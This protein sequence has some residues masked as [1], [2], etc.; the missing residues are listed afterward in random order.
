MRKAEI[1]PGLEEMCSGRG[2]YWDD[3][4]NETPR[5][6]RNLRAAVKSTEIVPTSQI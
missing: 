2:T 4:V 5:R 1:T 6:G 3:R